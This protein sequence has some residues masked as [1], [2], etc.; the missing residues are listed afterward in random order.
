MLAFGVANAVLVVVVVR[1][2]RAT[3]DPDLR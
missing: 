3:G 1:R 2:A